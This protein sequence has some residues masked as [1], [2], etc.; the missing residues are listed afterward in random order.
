VKDGLYPSDG[1]A[2]RRRDSTV[3]IAGFPSGMCAEIE[4]VA[5]NP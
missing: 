3:E 5:Y 4:G 1:K 2:D